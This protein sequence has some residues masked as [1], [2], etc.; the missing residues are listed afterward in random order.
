MF[1]MLTRVIHGHIVG[2]RRTVIYGQCTMIPVDF[3][4]WLTHGA[5]KSIWHACTSL[6]KGIINYTRVILSLCS[7]EV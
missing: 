2:L 7:H 5:Y 4:K 3:I 1:T 6:L